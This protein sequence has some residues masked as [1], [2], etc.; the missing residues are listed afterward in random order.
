MSHGVAG[1]SG[2]PPGQVLGIVAI[3]VAV[4]LGPLGMVLGFISR[5]QAMRGGGPAGLGLA[6]IIVGA[7]TTLALIVTVMI[8]LAVVLVGSGELQV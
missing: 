5:R 2:S 4:F 7:L 8:L 3:I 1:A 6:A